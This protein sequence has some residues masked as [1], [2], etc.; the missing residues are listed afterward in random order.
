MSPTSMTCTLQMKW[1]LEGYVPGL[2]GQCS[3]EWQNSGTF[4]VEELGSGNQNSPTELARE[5]ET[6]P[7][8]NRRWKA[9]TR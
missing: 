9:E 4:C 5:I 3:V 8:Q 1:E 6:V 2:K 7:F